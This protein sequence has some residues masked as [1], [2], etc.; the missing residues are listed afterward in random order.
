MSLFHGKSA[1][2]QAAFGKNFN[3]GFDLIFGLW[4]WESKV[5]QI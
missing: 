4:S 3:Q 5:I 2:K 1:S